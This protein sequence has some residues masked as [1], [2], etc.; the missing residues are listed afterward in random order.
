[1]IIIARINSIRIKKS[2]NLQLLNL[3][4]AVLGVRC[5]VDNIKLTANALLFYREVYGRV[6]VAW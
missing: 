1:M 5:D 2:I 4:C 3:I 6:H